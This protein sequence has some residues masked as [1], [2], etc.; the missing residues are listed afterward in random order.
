MSFSNLNGKKSGSQNHLQIL[1][2]VNMLGYLSAKVVASRFKLFLK[3]FTLSL[4]TAFVLCCV[5]LF[6]LRLLSV[7][8]LIR[9]FISYSGDF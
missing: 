4:F 5:Q 2:Q 1:K 8:T 7:K 9:N 6:C 3:T